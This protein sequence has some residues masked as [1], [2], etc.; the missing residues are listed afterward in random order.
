MKT[1]NSIDNPF[2]KNTQ[3]KFRTSAFFSEKLD[4]FWRHLRN[5]YPEKYGDVNGKGDFIVACILNDLNSTP[6][7]K[8]LVEMY[9]DTTPEI[10]W[11]Q[12]QKETFEE[13]LNKQ[14]SEIQ[15]HMKKRA[16]K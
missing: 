1:S 14:K 16:K 2:G 11:W 8:K 10:E 3:V 7:G 4:M 12:N 5:A 6:K 15:K 9:A 13:A